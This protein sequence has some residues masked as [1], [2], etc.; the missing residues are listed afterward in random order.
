MKIKRI[1]LL[2][3]LAIVLYFFISVVSAAT[4]TRQWDGNGIQVTLSQSDVNNI[5][6][7]NFG[8]KS[9]TYSIVDNQ[10]NKFLHDSKI[11]NDLKKKGLTP[12]TYFDSKC[13]VLWKSL[14]PNNYRDRIAWD[15]WLH[16]YIF[17]RRIC[18]PF[19]W[20]CWSPDPSPGTIGF[21]SWFVTSQFNNLLD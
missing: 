16:G 1:G 2:V 6:S 12:E 11:V 4:V 5:Q 8:P 10:I 3:G 17:T 19:N 21:D 14:W 20:G 15:T 9:K 18:L 13:T 7:E